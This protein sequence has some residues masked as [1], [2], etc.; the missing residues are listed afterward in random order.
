MFYAAIDNSVLSNI[1]SAKPSSF[2]MYSDTWSAAGKTIT[3]FSGFQE[4]LG[5]KDINPD[6]TPLTS[7]IWFQYTDLRPLVKQ[8]KAPEMETY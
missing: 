5:V 8:I 1:L 2:R 7:R 3:V 6:P 4:S